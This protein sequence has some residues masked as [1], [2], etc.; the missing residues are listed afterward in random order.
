MAAEPLF[1]FALRLGDNDLI[2]SQRLGAWCG[3]GPVLEED[4]ALANVALDLLGQARLWLG[5]AAKVEGAGR[6]EDQ[7]A[8]LRDAGEFRN[9]LLTEQPNGDYACTT[10]RQYFFDAWH[11]LLLDTLAAGAPDP[12][13]RDIAAKARIEVAYH[14]RRSRDWVIRLGDGSE[15]SHRRTQA[16]VA[17]LW[18]FAGEMFAADGVDAAVCDLAALRGPWIEQVQSTL[19]Q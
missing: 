18:P 19:Q 12:R 17:E 5:L 6:N 7:L 10:V 4:L 9:L 8:Y 11:R 14:L 2:L 16:A 15:E 3:H 13:V 1:E